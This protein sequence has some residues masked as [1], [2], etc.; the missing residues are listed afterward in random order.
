MSQHLARAIA[1]NQRRSRYFLSEGLRMSSGDRLGG[2]LQVPVD[3]CPYGGQVRQRDREPFGELRRKRRKC[4]ARIAVMSPLS[5]GAIAL[6]G[7][8]PQPE[9]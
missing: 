4:A 7:G 3:R 2:L 1:Y 6:S 8:L 9:R 5:M